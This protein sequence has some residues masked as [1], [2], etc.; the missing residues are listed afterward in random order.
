MSSRVS[1]LSLV[2]MLGLASPALAQR[3][4]GGGRGGQQGGGRPAPP[5]T[6]EEAS[7][8]A[9]AKE[10][11]DMIEK[12]RANVVRPPLAE[13]R[14]PTQNEKALSRLRFVED[15]RGELKQY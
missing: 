2:C 3:M 7:R 14:F 12:A 5:P 6:S 1:G 13:I 10:W 15:Q 8:A 9:T 11:A 4:G